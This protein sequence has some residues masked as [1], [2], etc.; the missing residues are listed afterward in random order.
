MSSLPSNSLPLN[1][2]PSNSLTTA[3][4]A[5]VDDDA[6]VRFA[7]KT[8]LDFYQFDVQEFDSAESLLE[9]ESLANFDC[10]IID[11]RMQ[12]ISGLQLLLELKRRE[13]RIPAIVVSGYI[14]DAE[15]AEL[16]VAGASAIMEKPVKAKELVAEL[17]R[18][19]QL[20]K[21]L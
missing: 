17:T 13:S 8:L 1:S 14:S 10:L 18:L 12:G 2:L 7:T 19:I 21:T 16:S 5:L 11:Y 6:L 20:R 3:L 15:A 9:V 4:I